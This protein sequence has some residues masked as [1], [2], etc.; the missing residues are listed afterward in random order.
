MAFNNYQDTNKQLRMLSHSAV[1]EESTTPYLLRTTMVLI[2]LTVIA[3][4][5][6]SSITMVKEVAKTV[7]EV[8]PTDYVQS[9]QHLEGGIISQILVRDDDVVEQGQTLIMLRGEKILSDY[10]R[11]D[12]KQLANI[13]KAIRLRALAYGKAPDFKNL[14]IT[15][16]DMVD[17]E[18]KIIKGMLDARAYE[19]LIVQEQITQKQ[20]Q[21]RILEKE[22]ETTVGN[23][24]IVKTIF[25][26]QHKL[27]KERLVSESEYF[28]AMKEKNKLEGALGTVK[29]KIVQAKQSMNEYKWRLKSSQSSSR[30]TA[31]QDLSEVESEI[32]ETRKVLGKLKKQTERLVIKSPVDGVVKG[33]T[34]HTI[35]GVVPPGSIIMEIVP[36][37]SELIANIKI[38][39]NEI[40]HIRIG[41]SANVTVTA[42]DPSRYGTLNGSVIGISATTFSDERGI[43][44][45]KGMVKLDKN[46]FGNIVGNNVI[47][48]GMIVNADIITG[49]KSLL[50][51]LLKPIH[52]SLT[53]AFRE[54]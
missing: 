32:A 22:E 33:L 43:V 53:S 13:L 19:Q 35:G 36:V 8:I 31:L 9:L 38:P 16:P 3:F 30:E 52:I 4:I 50:S 25:K 21:L 23:L 20:E 27:Y 54:R 15:H 41:H 46:Y 2:C 29:I 42:Y 34:V 24:K 37:D 12:T 1:L 48:P 14:N 5:G 18:K 39:P 7:G 28:D 10:D 26:T 17:K 47:L 44:Y 51:Y 45:Y 6:W 49:E 11:I 40:G